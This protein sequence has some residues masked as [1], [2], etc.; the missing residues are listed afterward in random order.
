MRRIVAC[1]VLALLLLS[2]AALPES[3]DNPTVVLFSIDFCPECLAA[4][5]WFRD[6]DIAFHEFNIEHSDYA[7][8]QFE[9]IGGRG[10]P[11]ILVDNKRFQGFRPAR[12]RRL[13]EESD[14][15]EARRNDNDH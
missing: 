5:R 13:L 7:R 9:R 6:R 11:L 2:P 1:T 10:V 12:L 3:D 4:K 14:E 15:T 8:E